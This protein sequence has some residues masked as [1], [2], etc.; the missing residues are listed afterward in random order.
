M[1]I[2]EKKELIKNAINNHNGILKLA[3]TW[4][5]RSFMI[6]G[7]RFKLDPRD[8]YA[9]GSKRGGISERW[10]ASTTKA[11]NGLE[12]PEDEG[13]SYIVV[14]EAY[15]DKRILLKEAIELMGDEILGE[16]VMNKY[17]RWFALAKI[18]DFLGQTPF[19]IHQSDNYAK[20]VGKLGKPEAYY[21]PMQLNFTKGNFPYSFFGLDPTTKKIDIINCL[22]KWDNGYN[23]ILNYSRAYK[24]IPG[25]GWDI[26]AGIL[27]G[28]GTLVTFE[29]QR[30]S[31]VHMMFQSM[32]D[33]RRVSKELLTKDIPEEYQNDF[34]YIVNVL[35]WKGNIDPGFKER[36]F[37]EPKY[38]KD[39]Q[40]TKKEGYIE[41]LII[42]KS[43]YF[44]AKEIIVFPDR[45][46]KI[47]EES[48]FGAIIIQG[49][50]LLNDVQIESPSLIKYG[51]TT[52]DEFFITN[53]A[54]QNLCI[55]NTSKN[56]NLVILEHFGP[57]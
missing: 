38:I 50:G 9:L 7:G 55:K 21:F 47:Q 44:S 48:A 14:D 51:Q 46:I 32:I 33:G 57:K 37:C 23:D 43:K 26:P 56:E 27:H 41:K 11:D 16:T 20:L 8:L 3:P 6:P 17:G 29:V 30:S 4:V 36:H 19:H 10:L 28:P 49:R 53:I 2:K 15:S 42:Y 18:Y 39:P 54:A 1:T 22:K 5:P 31:D 12:A 35:D 52:S 13:L 24:L 45:E 34:E 40:A 25:T